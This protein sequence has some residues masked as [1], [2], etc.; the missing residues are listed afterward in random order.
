VHVVSKQQLHA[1]PWWHEEI[2][3]HA[4]GRLADDVRAA[5]QLPRKFVGIKGNEE[6]LSGGHRSENWIRNSKFSEHKANDRTIRGQYGGGDPRWLA[7][8]DITFHSTAQL[9][10]VCR[11][12]DPAVR[13]GMCPTVTRW[14]GN[15]GNDQSPGEQQ[16]D[17]FDTV[18]RKVV[19]GDRSHLTHLHIEFARARAND[20]HSGVLA[21][22]TGELMDPK[23][24]DIHP[25]L[26]NHQV[27]RDMWDWLVAD[28]LPEHPPKDSSRFKFP[29]PRQEMLAELR[30]VRKAVDDLAKT[31][32]QLQEALAKS[33]DNTPVA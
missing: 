7:A 5:F 16:V 11:R 2:V 25:D 23:A 9:I 8:L 22:L 6:H 28:R 20:D 12:F 29:V 33:R 32:A 21:A 30:E 4:L 27:F 3:P 31:V 14:Y 18:K 17:G 26:A 19:R 10:E 1:E 15:L 13:A 24:R